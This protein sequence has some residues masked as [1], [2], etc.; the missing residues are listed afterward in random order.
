MEIKA[1]NPVGL[2]QNKEHTLLITA[3]F[4]LC[5]LKQLYRQGWLLRGVPRER[6]ESIA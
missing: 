4:E 2:L 6:C 3:Y 1:E 5:H